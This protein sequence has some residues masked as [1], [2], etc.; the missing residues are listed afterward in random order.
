MTAMNEGNEMTDTQFQESNIEG[1]DGSHQL[2]E[3][4]PGYPR[5]L[6]MTKSQVTRHQ[7]FEADLAELAT[8]LLD[9]REEAELLSHL[10]SCSS[11]ATEFEQ[12]ASA[13]KSL[14]QLVLEIEPPDGFESRFLD[15]LESCSSDS[16]VVDANTVLVQVR[17]AK[18][19][20][21]SSQS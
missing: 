1:D 4:R 16:G 2:L 5:C 18:A 7:R 3:S 19:A 6:S 9:T 17:G 11:C 15:R 8:G 21:G 12:L 10:V 14:L 20:K 13:A